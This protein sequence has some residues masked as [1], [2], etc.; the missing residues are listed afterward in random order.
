MYY[1]QKFM[2]WCM[3]ICFLVPSEIAR[4]FLDALLQAF[5]GGPYFLDASVYPITYVEN[6]VWS[7]SLMCN[8]H[9]NY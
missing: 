2:W 1:I 4:S 5:G 6:L 7:A 3:C 9:V 8:L